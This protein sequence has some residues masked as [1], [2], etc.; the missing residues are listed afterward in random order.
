MLTRVYPYIR[1]FAVKSNP[2]ELFGI[3]MRIVR[4]LLATFQ[5]VFIIAIARANIDKPTGSGVQS[6]TTCLVV[7]MRLSPGFCSEFRSRDPLV[8]GSRI[9]MREEKWSWFQPRINYER[10]RLNSTCPLCLSF[11]TTIAT[12]FTSRVCKAMCFVHIVSTQSRDVHMCISEAN[13][14][15]IE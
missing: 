12:L 4:K 10:A 11:C 15:A 3:F 14:S 1:N 13:R 5:F 2:R 8:R 6:A 7:S 9:K